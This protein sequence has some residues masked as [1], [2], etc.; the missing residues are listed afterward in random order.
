M[1]CT[2]TLCI[3]HESVLET[4]SNFSVVLWLTLFL[5]V[6]FW[7]Y[8]EN[9]ANPTQ[10][11]TNIMMRRNPTRMEYCRTSLDTSSASICTTIGRDVSLVR[12]GGREKEGGTGERRETDGQCKP[13]YHTC[14]H[15]SVQCITVSADVFLFGK[16]P[17]Y[18]QNTHNYGCTAQ[19]GTCTSTNTSAQRPKQLESWNALGTVHIPWYVC[20]QIFSSTLYGRL[21]L[22]FWKRTT[23][24]VLRD[25]CFES[26]YN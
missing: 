4:Q 23:T 7:Q 1:A 18:L 21:R 11:T 6:C 13:T 3:V 8:F 9:S 17:M 10:G 12:L 5:R 25:H 26:L 14:A 2:C 22:S 20:A 15:L 16:F 24:Q 19:R